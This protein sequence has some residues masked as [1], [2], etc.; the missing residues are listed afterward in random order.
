M[1]FKYRLSELRLNNNYTQRSL[2]D[3]LGTK[4]TTVSSW[5]RGASYPNTDMLFKLCNLFNVSSDYLLGKSDIK[6]SSQEVTEDDFT[7]AFNNLKGELTEEDKEALL[8]IAQSFVYKNKK[9]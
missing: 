1:L 6:K 4:P 2:A 9:D 3:A 8:K 7:I 5:E